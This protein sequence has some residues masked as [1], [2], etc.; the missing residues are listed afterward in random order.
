MSI[1][2]SELN[3][4]SIL[5]QDL[6]S[7]GHNPATSGNYSL[8]SPDDQNIIYISQSGVDKKNFSSNH[9]MPIDLHTQKLILNAGEVARKPS[10]ET[11]VHLA[12][13]QK[14]QANCILHT[15]MLSVLHFSDLFLN[16]RFAIVE[17]LEMLKALSGI[18]THQAQFHIPCFDN[19]QMMDQLALQITDLLGRPGLY[20]AILLRHHGLYVW[21]KSIDE[22]KR[23]LEAFEYVMNY[24]VN[25]KIR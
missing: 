12:I 5:I 18:K 21:G 1:I 9:F 17:N 20:W 10:D 6:N 15:H 25:K 4:L 3:K 16:E 8:R 14:T 7:K 2:D 24:Y 23:H 19:T 13:Y 11:A 22:A